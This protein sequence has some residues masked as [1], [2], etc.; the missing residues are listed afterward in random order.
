M[1]SPPPSVTVRSG[2]APRKP[3]GYCSESGETFIRSGGGGGGADVVACNG[4]SREV[5]AVEAIVKRFLFLV[6]VVVV[7]VPVTP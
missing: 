7:W 1:S 2:T 6:S 5:T 4:F 3:G